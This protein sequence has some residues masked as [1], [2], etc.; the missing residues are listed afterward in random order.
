MTDETP[1]APEESDA[2]KF[3]HLPPAVKLEDTIAT[4][5]PDAP[6]DPTFGR[7]PETEFLLR[8]GVG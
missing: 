4:H 8:H 7:D 1:G 2:D 6:A 5:N 3:K